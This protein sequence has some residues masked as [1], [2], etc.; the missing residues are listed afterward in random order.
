MINSFHRDE[1]TIFFDSVI[2]MSD[3]THS[4]ATKKY[5][6][7]MKC[8]KKMLSNDR[9]ELK[10]LVRHVPLFNGNMTHD[11]VFLS[12]RER[13]SYLITTFLPFLITMPL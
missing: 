4:L 6:H 3:N 10:N 8:H 11:E 13:V 7:D 2:L 1:K 12:V 9:F 5:C